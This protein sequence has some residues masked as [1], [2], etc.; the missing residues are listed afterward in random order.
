MLEVC[1]TE[2]NALLYKFGFNAFC[3][4][5]KLPGE[6]NSRKINGLLMLDSLPSNSGELIIL[7]NLFEN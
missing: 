6:N 3:K 2:K 7:D 1:G 5:R 4:I